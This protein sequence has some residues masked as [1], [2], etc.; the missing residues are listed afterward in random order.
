MTVVPSSIGALLAVMALLAVASL[1]SFLNTVWRDEPVSHPPG[2]SNKR[3][4]GSSLISKLDAI[5][6]GSTS[7]PV[8]SRTVLGRI[9]GCVNNRNKMR[10]H[11]K[12]TSP[13]LSR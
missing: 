11:N 6:Q 9:C 2:W 13:H 1:E 12:A 3:F 5:S 7:Q 8:V 4:W 10:Q